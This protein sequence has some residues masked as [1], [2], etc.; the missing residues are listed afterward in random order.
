M[1]LSNKTTLENLPTVYLG[2]INGLF[3]LTE[4]EIAALGKIVI[5][6]S[7]LSKGIVDKE[8]LNKMLFSI[9]TRREIADKI[10]IKP[11][12]LASI[13]R[14]LI[15]KGALVESDEGAISVIDVCIPQPTITFK[16]IIVPDGKENNKGPAENGG[17][18]ENSS[19]ENRGEHGAGGSNTQNGNA[20]SA[21]ISQDMLDDETPPED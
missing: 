13:I 2:T 12:A 14:Q 3:G 9:D 1:V 4:K 21:S 19:P 17:N 10:G 7:E 11:P 6:Y 5:S 18:M 20:S 8:I 16:L 15:K